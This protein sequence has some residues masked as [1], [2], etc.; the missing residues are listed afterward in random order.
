M[1]GWLH[2]KSLEKGFQTKSYKDLK[3]CLNNFNIYKNSKSIIPSNILK[4]VKENSTSYKFHVKR[5]NLS[6][7]NC[8]LG[9]G[10]W[11]EYIAWEKY[12]ATYIMLVLNAF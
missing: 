1:S 3:V 2:R 9:R 5:S 7:K 10:I 8:C 12:D 6:F 4:E 11:D